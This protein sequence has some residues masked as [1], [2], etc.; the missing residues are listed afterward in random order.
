MQ[1]FSKEKNGVQGPRRSLSRLWAPCPDSTAGPS[2]SKH[3]KFRMFKEGT[4]KVWVWVGPAC[5]GLSVVLMMDFPRKPTVGKPTIPYLT[6][7]ARHNIAGHFLAACPLLTPRSVIQEAHRWGVR[8]L[9]SLAFGLGQRRHRLEVRGRGQRGQGIYSSG[10]FPARPQS[11][12]HCMSLPKATA[13]TRNPFLPW[14]WQRLLPAA[15]PD[16]ATLLVGF[17]S[18]CPHVCKWTLV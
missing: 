2:C 17:L 14:R 3:W 16:A 10:F 1:R 11:E 9:S 5:T 12:E 7:K 6:G 8:Q 18:S 15:A 13:L 4:L